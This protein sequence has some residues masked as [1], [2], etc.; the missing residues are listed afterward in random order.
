[1]ITIKMN[2]NFLK[3]QEN[4]RR[5][6]KVINQKREFASKLEEVKVMREKLNDL[7]RA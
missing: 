7:N 4:L 2:N 6:K 1:M 3:I 5:V